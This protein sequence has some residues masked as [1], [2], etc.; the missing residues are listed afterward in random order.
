M[1]TIPEEDDDA[2]VERLLDLIGH[3]AEKVGGP[4]LCHDGQE[5]RVH[6]DLAMKLVKPEN[7]AL[8]LLLNAFG[9][10]LIIGRC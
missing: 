8:V 5:L 10:A 6:P 3:V 2:D 9:E 7:D 1:P 4:V